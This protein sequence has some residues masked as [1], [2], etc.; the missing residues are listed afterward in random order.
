MRGLALN[1]EDSVWTKYRAEAEQLR[2]A[3]GKVVHR[4]LVKAPDAVPGSADEYVELPQQRVMD[5][6][7]AALDAVTR[8]LPG[9]PKPSSRASYL[10][11]RRTQRNTPAAS[12]FVWSEVKAQAEKLI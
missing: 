7:T 10:V 1:R 8:F 11:W 12:A 5:T 6:D 9:N 2:R 3:A 4:K